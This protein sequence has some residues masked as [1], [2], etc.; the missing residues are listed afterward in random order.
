[1]LITNI[2]T[3]HTQPIARWGS[4]PLGALNCT[5]PRPKAAIATKACS[6]IAGL[7]ERSGA[8]VTDYRPILCLPRKGEDGVRRTPGGG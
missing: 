2:N 6:L 8:S 1:M 3:T 7:A 5:T 4:V